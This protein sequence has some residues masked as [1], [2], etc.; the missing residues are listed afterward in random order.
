M[1][2]EASIVVPVFNGA[3][4]IAETVERLFDQS[5]PPKE[6]IFVDDGSTDNT[7]ET[8]NRVLQKNRYSPTKPHE[9]NTKATFSLRDSSCDFVDESIPEVRVVTKPNGGPASARNFGARLATAE[10]IAF[11]D[12]DCLPDREWLKNLL[13]G[14]DSPNVAGVGGSVKSVDDSLIGEYVD[15][16]Q[17]LEPA[18]NPNG[19][20]EYLITANA[21]F[22]REAL[23]A[24][25]LFDEHFRKPGGEEPALCRRMKEL[26]HQFRYAPQAVVLHHHRQTVGSFLRTIR[27]YGEGRYLLGKLWPDY[28]IA[29]PTRTFFRQAVAIRSL[30]SGFPAYVRQHGVKKA[31]AF[32]ALDYLRQ[33]AFLR[34][35]LRGVGTATGKER[36]S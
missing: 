35:Y 28:Q 20:I 9:E 6:I 25:E 11:T 36:T 14:F 4:T 18:K 23:L 5:L 2:V 17:M 12:S 33:L 24:V 15:L 1:H 16:L 22:R 30:A 31:L 3:A 10:F 32:S 29:N 19:E 34:G 7:V 13:A 8:I 21:C 27:N 26:G